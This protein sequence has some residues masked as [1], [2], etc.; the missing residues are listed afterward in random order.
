M[1]KAMTWAAGLSLLALAAAGPAA[2]TDTR[3]VP[4]AAD[5]AAAPAPV[6][7]DLSGVWILDEKASDDPAAV[8]RRN[9]ERTG[10]Q[11]GGMGGPGGMQGRGGGMGGRQGGMQ[12]DPEGGGRGGPGGGPGQDRDR[13]MQRRIARLE[14]FSDGPEFD[15]TDGLDITRVL[16]TDGRTETVWTERGEQQATAAWQDGVLEV[17]WQGRGGP[18]RTTRFSLEGDGKQLV[19]LE[20]VQMP[21][22]DEEVT[23]R[24]VYDR[25]AP[26]DGAAGGGQ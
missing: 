13:T 26:A 19:V 8:M 10:G 17:R 20:Q 15:V 9:W 2:A 24:L 25:Q 18:G 3:D 12:D 23:L 6:H 7:P 22:S 5:T 14:I 16:H 21:G 4:A 11:R 1:R